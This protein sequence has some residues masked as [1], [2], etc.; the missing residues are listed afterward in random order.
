MPNRRRGGRCHI[1][2]LRPRTRFSALLCSETD[3]AA[4]RRLHEAGKAHRLSY[5]VR[6]AF[7]E[8]RKDFEV[9]SPECQHMDILSLSSRS[10]SVSSTMRTA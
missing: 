6:S 7:L 5:Q 1:E 2:C 3:E 10:M 8:V 4:A 9:S